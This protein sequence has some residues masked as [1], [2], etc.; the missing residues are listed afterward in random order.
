MDKIRHYSTAS[1]KSAAIPMLLV[2]EFR[3]GFYNYLPRK[4]ISNSSH[5][6]LVMDPY[7]IVSATIKIFKK[8][9]V[10]NF[11]QGLK[12]FEKS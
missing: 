2:A 6:D 5:T 11:T 7:H 10:V 12:G 3:Q 9:V 8:R 1:E 4:L